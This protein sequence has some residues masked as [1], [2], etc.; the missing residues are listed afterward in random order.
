MAQRVRTEVRKRGF[1]G[2]VFMVLFV[3]FNILMLAWL[4][5]VRV[6]PLV[7]QGTEHSAARTGAAVGA[8]LATGF[9]ITVWAAGDIILGLLAFLSRG[10]KI[11]VEEVIQ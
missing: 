11:I 6:A 5:S 2:K 4:T 1:F 7:N 8:T 3:L 10:K 9:L